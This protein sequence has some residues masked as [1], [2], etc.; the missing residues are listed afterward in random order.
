MFSLATIRQAATASVRQ[1]VVLG[2]A[3]PLAMRRLYATE[4]TEKPKEEE[5]PAA[6]KSEEDNVK[7]DLTKQ[8]A[9]KVKKI[10][11]LQ[12]AYLRC[13]ADQENI[14]ERSRKEV[15]SSKEFAIQKFAKDL[16]DTVDILGMALS[17]VPLELREKNE[18]PSKEV[19]HDVER[20][21]DQLS[22]LYKG[23]S[24]TETELLKTLKRHGVEQE[25]PEGETFDPNRHQALF[26]APMPDKEAGTVF[27][28]QKK[29]YSIKGRVLRPAQ[30]GVVSDPQ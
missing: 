7:D 2:R 28:V 6:E 1:S 5:K 15:L 19:I 4:N 13:L 8:L 11:E 24:M 22:N 16:L 18:K 30:V 23:V 26:Q 14:R 10:A 3:S 20:V 25:N 29:G 27:S 17:A 9:E 21:L 12:D